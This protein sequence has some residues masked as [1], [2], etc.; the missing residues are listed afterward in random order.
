MTES[1]K[2]IRELKIR[3]H[4]LEQYLAT[5]NKLPILGPPNGKANYDAAVAKA[6]KGQL[7]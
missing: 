3:V 4:L 7:S 6:L 5:A 1:E 2:Q